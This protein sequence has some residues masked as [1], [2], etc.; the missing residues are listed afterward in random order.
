ME[1]ANFR[2]EA[3]GINNAKDW[4]DAAGLCAYAPYNV[5]D[6]DFIERS[7]REGC[8]SLSVIIYEAS[9]GK[10]AAIFPAELHVKSA[11]FFKVRTAK[12]A[13][14]G[15]LMIAGG[16][17]GQAGSIK[18]YFYENVISGYYRGRAVDMVEVIPPPLLAIESPGLIHTA[19][20][21]YR[22][23]TE[24][25]SLLYCD[26]K[27]DFTAKFGYNVKRES[28]KGIDALNGLKLMTGPEEGII[29]LLRD[30]ES[31]KA[32][33]LNV[34]PI[35][36]QALE[37]MLCSKVVTTVIAVSGGKALAAVSYSCRGRLATLHYNAS[38][39][40]GKKSFVNKGL[41]LR[42]MLDCKDKGAEYFVLGNGWEHGRDRRES[43]QLER[44]AFFKRSFST[45][46][47]STFR[48]TSP[49]TLKGIL[50]QAGKLAIQRRER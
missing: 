39:P 14:Y 46:E 6:P 35:P 21:F 19:A 20:P 24:I 29:G 7:S 34:D 17:I 30:L 3:L 10:P 25:N 11:P 42:C 22:A 36:G 31:G 9:S 1:A 28:L 8:G 16:Y 2:C 38:T 47:A 44:M 12:S 26:L 15:G 5:F 37:K 27:G 50:A 45:S 23:E 43:E 4:L 40:E 13:A 33:T 18:K 32:A 41:M 49:L 48:F